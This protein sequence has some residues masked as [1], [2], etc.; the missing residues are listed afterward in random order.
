M[1]MP[2][3]KNI[4]LLHK[5]APEVKDWMQLVQRSQIFF[6]SDNHILNIPRPT[7]PN[8]V[9]IPSLNMEPAR[10]LTNELEQLVNQSVH[11]VILLTFGSTARNIP[12]AA[13]KKILQTFSRIKQVHKAPKNEYLMKLF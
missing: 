8:V 2:G 1:D 10:P 4:T 5:H 9:L 7:L 3:L 13:V 12:V 6:V 11:G